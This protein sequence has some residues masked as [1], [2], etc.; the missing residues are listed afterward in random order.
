MYTNQIMGEVP[1]ISFWSN[2][3]RFGLVWLDCVNTDDWSV[4]FFLLSGECFG[5]RSKR[6]SQIFHDAVFK[7]MAVPTFNPLQSGANHHRGRERSPWEM[8]GVEHRLQLDFGALS[9]QYIVFIYTLTST[10]TTISCSSYVVFNHISHKLLVFVNFKC[11]NQFSVW[12]WLFSFYKIKI[13]LKK[14]I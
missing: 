2:K 10:S 9:G 12:A 11:Q 5:R 8:W 4:F 7:E 6:D 1:Y 14:C 3:P 13:I